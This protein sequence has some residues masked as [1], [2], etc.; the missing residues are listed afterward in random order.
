MDAYIYISITNQLTSWGRVFFDRLQLVGQ[1]PPPC[2][3]TRIM[4]T[5]S[6]IR[7][8]LERVQT[9]WDLR[10]SSRRI[11][12]LRSSGMLRTVVWFSV[13]LF[14][15][16]ASNIFF[17][18]VEAYLSNTSQHIPEQSNLAVHA[19]DTPE[20]RSLLAGWA[21]DFSFCLGAMSYTGCR[22]YTNTFNKTPRPE[23]ASELYRPRDRRLSA[24]LVPTVADRG[25]HVVSVTDPYGHILNFQDRSRYIFLQVA[26]QL[27]LRG[28]VDPV[29]DPIL[30]RKSGSAGN[31]TPTSGSAA[32]NS[33]H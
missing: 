21:R 31:R 8:H 7:S 13:K 11:C 25:C 3:G 9:T 10:F 23:S 29:P 17:W 15:Y 28:W 2:Q 27:Y 33:N 19:S 5:A 4:I 24:N 1:R 18:K 30:L 22:G 6:I 20:G 14:S 26:L 16:P 32:R 12:G